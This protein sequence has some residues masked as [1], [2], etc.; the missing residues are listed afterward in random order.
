MIWS[1]TASH[2]F[3]PESEEEV[4]CLSAAGMLSPKCKTSLCIRGVASSCG[5]H[6]HST[7]VTSQLELAKGDAVEVEGEEIEGWLQVCF[8]LCSRCAQLQAPC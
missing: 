2:A 4:H 3:T 7:I 6:L 5:V 8:C 1:G